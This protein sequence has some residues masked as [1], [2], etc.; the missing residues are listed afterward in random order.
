M[1]ASLPA[2]QR[3]YL[4]PNAYI[5]ASMTNEFYMTSI[6]RGLP[7]ELNSLHA[8]PLTRAVSGLTMT[9]T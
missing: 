9:S 8:R 2:Y 3:P 1:A 6:L 7:R 5:L 4:S